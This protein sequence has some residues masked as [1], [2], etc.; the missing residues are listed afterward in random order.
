MTK[1]TTRPD[2]ANAPALP[3]PLSA[4]ALQITYEVVCVKLRREKSVE[5]TDDCSPAQL[6]RRIATLLTQARCGLPSPTRRA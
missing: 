6:R 1:K 2:G 5:T 4:L 3:A